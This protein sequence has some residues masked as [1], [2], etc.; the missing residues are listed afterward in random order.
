MHV[1]L[2][3]LSSAAPP[4]A[5]PQPPSPT[6]KGC[7]IRTQHS[8]SSHR[9]QGQPHLL[10]TSGGTPYLRRAP[11]EP[12]CGSFWHLWLSGF[13]WPLPSWAWASRSATHGG[14][15]RRGGR[16]PHCAPDPR[17][18]WGPRGP[19]CASPGSFNRCPCHMWTLAD[20]V[21]SVNGLQLGKLAKACA[22]QPSASAL[23]DAQWLTRGVSARGTL[24]R[25]NFDEIVNPARSA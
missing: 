7:P 3:P 10:G 9:R 16:S 12:R 5:L 23:R 17:R 1:A 19:H 24:G 21:P 8:Q 2:S 11:A 13:S 25:T 14:R 6:Q 4:G 20:P 15:S 18:Q 22:N